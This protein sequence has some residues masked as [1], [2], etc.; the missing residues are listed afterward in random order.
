MDARTEAVEVVRRYWS[1]VWS[2]DWDGVGRTLADDVEVFWPVTR[3]IIRGRDNMV[4]VN[5]QYPNGWSIDV[6]NAYDAGDVVISEVQVPQEDVGIFR[7]VSLWTVIDGVITSGR[8][9]WTLYGGEEGADWRRR[10]TDV[11]DLPS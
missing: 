2:R 10:Y 8:E 11:G 6:L 4:A 9:Y 1:S 7:V 3:E 5:S